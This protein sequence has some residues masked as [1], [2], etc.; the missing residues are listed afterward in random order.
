MPRREATIYSILLAL[1]IF[2]GGINWWLAGGGDPLHPSDLDGK[3]PEGCGSGVDGTSSSRG[4][5]EPSVL[6]SSQPAPSAGFGAASPF[7]HLDC[8]TQ[9]TDPSVWKACNPSDKELAAEAVTDRELSREVD[10]R[11]IPLNITRLNQGLYV[12]ESALAILLRYD[13][14]QT[15][16]EGPA[17]AVPPST[18]EECT[19]ARWQDINSRADAALIQAY[20]RDPTAENEKVLAMWRISMTSRALRQYVAAFQ[21][22]KDGVSRGGAAAARI[23]FLMELDR[24]KQ[25]A[26]NLRFSNDSL[27]DFLLAM[28]GVE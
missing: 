18:T 20:G 7:G 8:R 4:C 24:L 23:Q 13:G 28:Q 2:S 25:F 15:A 10:T 1:V 9:Y 16:V 22:E 11:D 5:G 26:G 6:R 3:T 27:N 21:G 17:A 12:R 14:C 19:A